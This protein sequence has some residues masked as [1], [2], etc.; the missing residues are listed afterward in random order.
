MWLGSHV[1]KVPATQNWAFDAIPLLRGF[2]LV[3]A[4]LG[5]VGQMGFSSLGR[6]QLE[7]P[8]EEYPY[9]GLSLVPYLG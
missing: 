1:R 6:G 5:E 2:F 3:Q 7:A 8:T 4:G 9:F